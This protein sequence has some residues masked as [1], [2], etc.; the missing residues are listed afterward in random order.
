[1]PWRPERIGPYRL[2]TRLGVGGMGEVYRAFDERLMRRVALKLIRPERAASPVARERFR[3]EARAAAGLNHPSIVQIYDVV[4]S[5]DGDAI[6]LEYVE[7]TTLAQRL[8][9]GPLPWEVAAG[10]GR[11]IAEGLA[12]A[13]ARGIVH[14]DLKAENVMVDA[15]GRVKILDFGLAKR[16]EPDDLEPS[17]TREL[18][19]AGTPRAMS[20]EAA[21]GLPVDARSDL[22]SFGSLLYEMLAGRSPFAVASTLDTLTNVCTARQAP[23]R[24]L[25]PR[26]PPA[27]SDLVDRLLEKDPARRPASAAEVAAE[28]AEL[29]A[30]G[31]VP[32]AAA[33]RQDQTWIEG[34]GG[35]GRSLP[36][37][38]PAALPAAQPAVLPASSAPASVTSALLPVRASS[39]SWRWLLAG[40]VAAALVA[41][42]VGLVRRTAPAPPPLTVAVA[43]PQVAAAV[44]AE[45][46]LPLLAAG[47]REAVQ[48]GLLAIR[49]VAPL[50]SEQVD[51]VA[52]TPVKLA[53]AVAAEEVLTSRLDCSAE[54]CQV[55]LARV[56]GRDG[57]LLWTQSFTVARTQPYL[58]TETVEGYL[59]RAYPDRPPRPGTAGFAVQPKDYE[60]YLRLQ[61]ELVA[62]GPGW[63]DER[64]L[65][66]LRALHASSPSF[67]EAYVLEADAL[68]Q[69]FGA[70]RDAADLDAAFAAL[71]RARAIAPE[72][73]RPLL[74]QVALALR[75][76]RLERAEE[77]VA[78][79]ERLQ[80]GDPA[81]MGQR[82]QLLERQGKSREALQLM[83]EAA[84][85]R[86]SLIHIVR[87][88]DMEYRLGESE[89]ARR[90]L[91]QVL[92][93]F[94]DY[95]SA[96]SLLAQIELNYGD[97][98]QA[99][100][101]YRALVARSPRWTELVNL[102]TAEMLLGRYAEAEGWLRRALDLEK[103]NP[104]VLLNLA[105]SLTL[106]GKTAAAAPLY[107]EML[108]L[109]AR[110]PAAESWQMVSARA[111]ALAHLGDRKRAVEAAQQVL[112]LAPDNA[113]AAQEAALIYTLV[114][115]QV[116]AQ[117]NAE[118]ALRQGVEPRW[119]NFPWFD[120]LRASVDFRAE[121]ATAGKR[122]AQR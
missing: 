89:F 9:L 36:P 8:A 35:I 110:D 28:L 57:A 83:T 90:H 112:R 33:S 45:S 113:Q 2:E 99:A 43:R 98:A 80:P 25:D 97:P 65:S 4:E 16:L 38:A 10:A 48:R 78:E 6:V 75:G 34:P 86:P 58:M 94:P 70:R 55:A 105:D 71:E 59:K 37:T 120:P 68:R 79:L 1:M 100:L 103:R 52:G 104:L 69:R 42:L 67:L 66:R 122:T 102:G 13:H 106:Q 92:A 18:A 29:G 95:R 62:P 88:A 121:L 31:V 73:P 26:L 51:A 84:R 3:R 41:G 85:L 111:Q 20:P 39:R 107:R 119:F 49:G 27:L 47:L 50:A 81:V 19:L 96:Q 118:R 32:P 82:A 44:A 115:D 56:R 40:L 72:D 46:D 63:S 116:S 77:A 53:R 101:L 15:A 60:E 61:A 91:R 74:A 109:I 11:A 21:R 30:S 108:P 7:G 14:R 24:E 93:R 23:L 114:G 12:A 117:Y 22:F 87:L 54:S 64:F 17:L 5:D 76:E